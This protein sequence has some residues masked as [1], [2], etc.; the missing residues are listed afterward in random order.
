MN[1]NY[2]DSKLNEFDLGFQT[3]LSIWV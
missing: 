1:L 3:N 2:D